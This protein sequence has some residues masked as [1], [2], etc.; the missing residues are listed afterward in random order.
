MGTLLT[1]RD[2]LR[3]YPG[4]LLVSTDSQLAR[5]WLRLGTQGERCDLL[6]VRED[7]AKLVVE[8][9]EVKT[10]KGKPRTHID[11]EIGKA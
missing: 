3:K 8:C 7:G 11:V 4:A 9:I 1:A 6:A 5:T 2:Y 10:T